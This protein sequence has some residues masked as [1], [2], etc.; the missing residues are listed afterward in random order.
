MRR[1]EFIQLRALT[2][3][4]LGFL[5]CSVPG[6]AQSVA[7]SPK[8]ESGQ[9][10]FEIGYLRL[11]LGDL[12]NA[13][14]AA[15]LPKI[16]EQF[17]TLGAAGYGERGRW[18]FGGQ[19]TGLIGRSK[20]TTNGAFDV[21][22]NGGYALFRVGY[23][24][25]VQEGF[26]LSPTFGIGAAGMQLSIRG[27]SAPT[28]NDILSAPGRSSTLANASFMLDLGAQAN[29]RIEI[30]TKDPN[31]RGGV[32][33]GMSAGYLF[34]P[35]TSNWQLDGLNSVAGGPT[36]KMQGVYVRLSVGGWGRKTVTK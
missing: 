4:G 36:V 21:S 30:G 16:D 7:V 14:V 26:E 3:M 12:N 11:D 35:A 34:A 2:A 23:K 27:R 32:L 28:F 31:E 1:H 19:G 20:A 8:I 5:L 6:A 18:L 24:V 15:N 10:A 13:M 22:L 29:G 9:G 33:V 25:V 17:L